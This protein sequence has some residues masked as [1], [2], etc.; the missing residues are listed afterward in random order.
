MTRKLLLDTD[1]G[2]D[3]AAAIAF[4]LGCEAIDTV[5]ITTVAGN[6]TVENTTEN[7]LGVLETLNRSDIPVA[8]GCD[9]PLVK[10]LTLAEHVHGDGGLYGELSPSGT[11]VDAHAVDFIIDQAR[12]HGDDLTIAAIGPLTN[13]A[14]AI[15]REP[16]LP[17]LVD[18]IYVMGGVAFEAGNATPVAEFNIYNDP[19]AASRVT[20]IAEPKIIGL[21]ATNDATLPYETVQKLHDRSPR[22]EHVAEWCEYAPDISANADRPDRPSLHD[23]A[24]V[25]AVVDDVVTFERHYTQI[26]TSGG[27]CDGQVVCDVPE[28]TGNLPNSEIGVDIDVSAFRDLLLDAYSNL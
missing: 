8:K 16:A 3:D 5:G 26:D 1:P 21:D 24:V 11:A 18:D 17:D 12:R 15:A 19:E 2:C 4:A 13:V 28:V 27:L 7:A 23:P 14:V 22:M 6:S 10:E 9:R 25:A 20:Q